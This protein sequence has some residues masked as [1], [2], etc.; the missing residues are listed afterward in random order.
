MTKLRKLKNRRIYVLP[1][2]KSFIETLLFPVIM[3]FDVTIK[4]RELKLNFI[5]SRFFITVKV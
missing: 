1:R 5:I 2:K 4:K 3:N